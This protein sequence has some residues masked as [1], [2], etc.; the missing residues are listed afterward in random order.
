MTYDSDGVQYAECK[1]CFVT[2]RI[3]DDWGR[4][5]SCANMCNGC[6]EYVD[7][8]LDG[9]LRCEMCPIEMDTPPVSPGFGI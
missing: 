1:D 4:C 2:K 3:A 7:Y 8:D 5:S 9:D 6:G